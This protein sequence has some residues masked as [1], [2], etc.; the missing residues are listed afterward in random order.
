MKYN[1]LY[2]KQNDDNSYEICNGYI[3]LSIVFDSMF[4]F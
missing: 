4:N 3:K 1:A 2:S